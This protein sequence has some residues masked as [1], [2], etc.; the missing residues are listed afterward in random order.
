[1]AKKKFNDQVQVDPQAKLIKKIEKIIKDYKGYDR[2]GDY[3]SAEAT[4]KFQKVAQELASLI[5]AQGV[6]N[7]SEALLGVARNV[8]SYIE[9]FGELNGSSVGFL[10]ED[11]LKGKETFPKKTKNPFAGFKF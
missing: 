10:F 7:T 2:D 3:F 11:G 9:R 5:S 1:M 6:D 8:S 4:P